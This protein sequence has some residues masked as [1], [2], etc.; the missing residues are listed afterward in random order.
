MERRVEGTH[1]LTQGQHMSVLLCAEPAA[2]ALGAWLALLPPASAWPEGL[3]PHSFTPS[4]FWPRFL[5]FLFSFIS[6][7]TLEEAENKRASERVG[8]EEKTGGPI[9]RWVS[10]TP[11]L[12]EK[13]R[14]AASPGGYEPRLWSQ[15][16]L[17]PRGKL[18]LRSPHLQRGLSNNNRS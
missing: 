18:C 5:L 17:S 15:L 2:A 8:D 16:Q 11:F 7:S 14:E 12:P 9:S 4:A 6:A 1:G 3:P 13:L 10:P